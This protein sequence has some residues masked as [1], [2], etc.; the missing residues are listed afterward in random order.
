MLQKRF[1]TFGTFLFSFLCITLG[2]LIILGGKILFKYNIYLIAILIIVLAAADLLKLIIF[3]GEQKKLFEAFTKLIIDFIFACLMIYHYDFII[4]VLTIFFGFYIFIHSLLHLFNFY[5]YK[6]NNISGKLAVLNSFLITFILS[7]LLIFHPTQN[8]I[9]AEII[10]GIYFIFLGITKFV[11]FI[12]EILPA[13]Y[14]NFLKSHIQIQLPILLAMFIPKQLISIINESL[15]LKCEENFILEKKKTTPDIEVIIHLATSGSAAFGH[16]EVCFEEKI[17]SFGNYDK[18]SRR[19]F[20]SIGDGVVC[21]ADK[22]Q[23]IEY[24]LKNKNRYLVVFG[25][26][27]TEKE[28][29]IIKKRI[30][31]LLNDNT[32]DF[33]PDLA[34]YEQGK[35]PEGTYNDMS[36][37]I[38]KLANGK[39]K[40]IIKGKNKKFFVF[41]TNCV[42]VANY[43]LNGKGTK[44]VAIN[45]IISPGSYYDYLNNEFLRK[46]SNVITRK[47]YTRDDIQEFQ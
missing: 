32:I 18:H 4:T 47:I 35:L 10:I 34:L 22:N 31:H 42:M 3:H 44:L 14:S 12:K 19:F 16:V 2:I 15:Q 1:N 23:Y 6:I 36:S 27:L 17:Y 30:Y 33:F 21:I 24:A 39:F 20:D 38:Y 7:L 41:K 43:I 5:L 9:F 46:N 29:M 26:Q 11:D 25:I 45:G 40:K 28:K 13:K 8:F 37:E